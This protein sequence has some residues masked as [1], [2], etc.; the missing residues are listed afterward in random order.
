M[1][2]S[3]NMF[4]DKLDTGTIVPND[5]L[6][7]RNKIKSCIVLGSFKLFVHSCLM[8]TVVI[9]LINTISLTPNRANDARGPFY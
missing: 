1:F 2:Q 8:N 4:Y 7:T 5:L 9:G 3:M 6:T